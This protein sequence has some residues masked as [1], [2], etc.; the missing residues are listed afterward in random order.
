MQRT[1]IT[2]DDDL[3]SRLDEF[4]ADRR[5][6]NRSGAIRDLVRAGLEQTTLHAAP[7]AQCL[8]AAIYVYDHESRELSSRLTRAAHEHHDLPLATLHVRRR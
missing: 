1:T 6:A 7:E 8:G 2:L 5:H 4:I 3:M